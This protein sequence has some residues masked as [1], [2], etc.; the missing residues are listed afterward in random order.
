M[1]GAIEEHGI[2]GT[3]DAVIERI[4]KHRA[5]G[6]SLFVIEFFGRDTRVPARLFA[7]KVAPAFA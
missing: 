3:P 5:L 1:G 7:E 6:V 2:W 4:E